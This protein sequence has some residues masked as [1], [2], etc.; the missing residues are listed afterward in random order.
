MGSRSVGLLAHSKKI[1]TQMAAMWAID[2]ILAR[3]N[4]W[5]DRISNFH[6]L[7]GFGPRICK[8]CSLHRLG[9]HSL[10]AT[11]KVKHR[12]DSD[13]IG[14]HRFIYG[15]RSIK[16]LIKFY[17]IMPLRKITK[18]LIIIFLVLSPII[19][20]ILWECFVI[21][22]PFWVY[23]YVFW[24]YESAGQFQ[25][26]IKLKFFN[27]GGVRNSIITYLLNKF[28]QFQIEVDRYFNSKV[29]IF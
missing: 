13:R 7:V 5:D 19:F 29:N 27:S 1:Q 14:N 11:S 9:H 8:K 16:M 22:S 10:I 12:F 28:D 2:R 26:M 24:N 15:L 21:S 4:I 18:W 25:E 3:F 23:F 17:I 20:K 6:D